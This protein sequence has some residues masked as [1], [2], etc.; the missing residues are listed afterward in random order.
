MLI[1]L[2]LVRTDPDARDIP[3]TTYLIM[4]M[5]ALANSASALYK[6]G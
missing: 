4:C 1:F 6:G 3:R 5:F 2:E